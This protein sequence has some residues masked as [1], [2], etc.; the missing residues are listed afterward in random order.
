MIFAGQ[1]RSHAIQWRFVA[2]C[3]RAYIRTRCK[4]LRHIHFHQC[5]SCLNPQGTSNELLSVTDWVTSMLLSFPVKH[6]GFS[7]HSPSRQ[8]QGVSRRS[9]KEKS[10]R[11]W[12]YGSQENQLAVSTVTR[13]LFPGESPVVLWGGHFE[14]PWRRKHFGFVTVL[15]HRTLYRLLGIGDCAVLLIL[16]NQARALNHIPLNRMPRRRIN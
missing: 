6:G 3:P 1:Q 9:D 10:T 4:R 14:T 2:I 15:M 8:L 11:C 13:L 7:L 5:T 12:A 16:S